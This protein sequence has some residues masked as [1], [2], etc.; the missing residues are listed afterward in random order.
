MK[1]FKLGMICL[2]FTLFTEQALANRPKV[3]VIGDSQSQKSFGQE[4]FKGLDQNYEVHSYSICGASATTWSGKYDTN[5]LRKK[6]DVPES[7]DPVGHLH[8]ENSESVG[9][10]T[11]ELTKGDGAFAVAL[12]HHRPDLV[13]IQLD[14]A[15]ESYFSRRSL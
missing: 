6:C 12:E 7:K 14:S 4:L 1:I 10:S 9:L 3:L 11:T 5:F 13:L 2:T 15:W 8:S